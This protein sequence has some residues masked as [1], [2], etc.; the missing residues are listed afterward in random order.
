MSPTK[1]PQ[2]KTSWFKRRMPLLGNALGVSA[3]IAFSLTFVGA[4]IALLLG[5]I[6]PRTLI[7]ATEIETGVVL[8]FVPLCALI[9]AILVE[10]TRSTLRDGLQAPR[11]RQSNPLSAWKPGHGEG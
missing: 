9:L 3:A 8:L 10:A 7:N 1:L 4:G 6:P 5:I 2:P 11:P